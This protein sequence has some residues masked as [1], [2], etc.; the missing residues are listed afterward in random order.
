[1]INFRDKV[2]LATLSFFVVVSARSETVSLVAPKFQIEIRD[3]ALLKKFQNPLKI[4]FGVDEKAILKG[5]KGKTQEKIRLLVFDLK[6]LIDEKAGPI[7]ELKKISDLTKEQRDEITM[8][9]DLREQLALNWLETETMAQLKTQPNKEI[10]FESLN[11]RL[12]EE[13]FFVVNEPTLRAFF[14]HKDSK[15]KV[16][17]CQVNKAQ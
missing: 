3:P 7:D 17:D 14:C 4:N 1:M 5:Y 9:G 12:L 11:K 8:L 15:L 13:F 16:V 6:D 2:L 10:S